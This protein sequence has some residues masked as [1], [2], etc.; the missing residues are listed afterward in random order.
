[1]KRIKELNSEFSV[2]F[3]QFGEKIA[4]VE[5]LGYEFDYSMPRHGLLSKEI[6]FTIYKS[7]KVIY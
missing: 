5:A 4:E 6:S 7:T 1:M 2:L 3:K